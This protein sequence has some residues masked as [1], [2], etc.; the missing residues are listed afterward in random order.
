MPGPFPAPPTF[1][2]KALGTRLPE[3][4]EAKVFSPEL[5]TLNIRPVDPQYCDGLQTRTYRGSQAVKAAFPTSF[6]CQSARPGRGRDCQSLRR[7]SHTASSPPLQ[8]LLQQPFPREKKGGGQRPVINLS[9]L[10]SFVRHHHFKMEDLKVF[11]DS[12]RPLDFMCKIDLKDTYFA[13]PIHP[14][15]QKLLCFQF[16][17]VTYQF[18]CLPFGLTSAP[19]VFTK[20]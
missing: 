3:G 1:K 9:T 17:N 5:G 14:A 8:S 10:D 4:R 2:G 20:C 18:K 6:E 15:H 7:E 16:K 12:L 13:V 11:A 19:R